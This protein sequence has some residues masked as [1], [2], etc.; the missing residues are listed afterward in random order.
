MYLDCVPL[1][2][3]SISYLRKKKKT[4]EAKCFHQPHNGRN[5][6]LTAN[7]VIVEII[8]DRSQCLMSK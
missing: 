5:F 2:Y 4:S 8:E 3:K 1:L 7:S 6:L